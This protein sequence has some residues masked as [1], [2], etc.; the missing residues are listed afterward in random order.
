MIL[1]EIFNIVSSMT[2]KEKSFFIRYAKMYSNNASN[3][4]YLLLYEKIQKQIQEGE[5][6]EDKLLKT[7]EKKINLKYL[8]NYKTNLHQQL[9]QSLI[10]YHRSTNLTRTI[11]NEIQMIQIL[12]EKG[13]RSIVQRLLQKTKTKA[14]QNEDFVNLIHIINIES[15]IIS[16][17]RESYQ[18]LRIERN[19]VIEQY[20]Q[21]NELHL[22]NMHY[23]SLSTKE[24]FFTREDK[25][26][27][28]LYNIPLL[29]ETLL[30]SDRAKVHAYMTKATLLHMIYDLEKARD[31]LIKSLAII[32]KNKI[33][34]AS[35]ITACQTIAYYSCCLKDKEAYHMYLEKARE[36]PY[37]I[38]SPYCKITDYL[39]LINYYKMTGGYK[40]GIK[41]LEDI[42]INYFEDNFDSIGSDYILF[43]AANIFFL[44]DAKVYL[45]AINWMN[46]WFEIVKYS[47]FIRLKLIIKALEMI[48]H[49]ELGNLLLLPSLFNSFKRELKKQLPINSFERLLLKF[50]YKISIIIDNSNK[51]SDIFLKMNQEME[52]IDLKNINP[53]WF[54]HFDF[55]KYFQEKR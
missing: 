55:I 32:E 34:K 31:Y 1:L 13:L 47:P 30:L 4:H 14:K 28:K 23:A 26:F 42:D 3:R 11:L 5:F 9:L 52:N 29:D 10:L 27:D 25:R 51:L 16:N 22:L 38:D 36:D 45:I 2:K 24:S 33:L 15:S 20:D 48:I 54:H 17:Q 19:F 12:Y 50:F 6:D 39:L 40:K 37:Y 18:L 46:K 49:L 7:L 43:V 41:M 21:V 35:R 8:N 53:I 44:C